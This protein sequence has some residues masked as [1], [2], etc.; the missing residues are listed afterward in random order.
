MAP[1]TRSR[2]R[3]PSKPAFQA[4]EIFGPLWEAR[5]YPPR[6]GDTLERFSARLSDFKLLGKLLSQPI[7][8]G[9]PES[10]EPLR[11]ARLGDVHETHARS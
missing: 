8:L 6:A 9:K 2:R 1:P 10:V 11:S 5:A 3:Y 4:E 7:G